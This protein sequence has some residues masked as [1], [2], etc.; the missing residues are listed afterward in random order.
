MVEK[1]IVIALGVIIGFT[2]SKISKRVMRNK[3]N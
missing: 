3:K 2:I 1:I